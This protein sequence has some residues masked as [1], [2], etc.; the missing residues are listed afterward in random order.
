MS[1]NDRLDI[2]TVVEQLY[3]EVQVGPEQERIVFHVDVL[4]SG[5]SNAYSA[6]IYRQDCF[7]VKVLGAHASGLPGGVAHHELWVVDDFFSGWDF[8]AHTA[9]EVIK[10]VVDGIGRTFQ[11]TE[12]GDD[13]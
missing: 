13:A 8:S 6:R 12:I 1:N 3:V 4:R 7:E 11:Q 2:F 10:L 9:A 5:A